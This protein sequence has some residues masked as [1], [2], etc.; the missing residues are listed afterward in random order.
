LG[1][2]T[3]CSVLVILSSITAGVAGEGAKPARLSATQITI[4]LIKKKGILGIYQG[5]RATMLRDVTFSG[6]YFPL[7]AHL[8]AMVGLT[9]VSNI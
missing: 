1:F 2:V 7:F 5:F 9:L 6:L 3:T 4:D 8:N